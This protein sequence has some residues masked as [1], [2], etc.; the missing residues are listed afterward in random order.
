MSKTIDFSKYSQLTQQLIQLEFKIILTN[1]SEYYLARANGQKQALKEVREIKEQLKGACIK[2]II[3][4]EFKNE[5][6]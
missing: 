1:R 5:N 3:I 6:R 2:G 4:E